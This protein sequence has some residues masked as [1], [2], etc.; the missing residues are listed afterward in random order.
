MGAALTAIG[1]LEF[2]INQ[3][4]LSLL[5]QLPQTKKTAFRRFSILLCSKN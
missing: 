4:I 2:A 1:S 3:T 5:K